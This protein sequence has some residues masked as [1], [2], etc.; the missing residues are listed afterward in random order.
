MKWHVYLR[1]CYIKMNADCSY[2]MIYIPDY[3][4]TQIF[5]FIN[6][7]A[8]IYIHKYKLEANTIS[9]F[10]CRIA[11]KKQEVYFSINSY[12]P[13]ALTNYCRVY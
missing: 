10:N 8:M 13:V 3:A 9:L 7:M 2:T 1:F 12:A 5:I 4:N 6:S 11:T